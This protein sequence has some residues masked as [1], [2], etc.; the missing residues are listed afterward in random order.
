MATSIWN[1]HY[2]S[3]I[4]QSQID[5]MLQKMYSEEALFNQSKSG[6]NFYFIQDSNNINVGFLSYTIQKPDAC[7]INKFYISSTQQGKGLGKKVFSQLKNSLTGIKRFQLT[8]NRQNYKAINFYFSLGFKIEKCED[9]DIGNG[10]F[11]NDFVMICS[12]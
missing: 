2:R 3:I 10:Y 4:G 11:M 7:F 6:Q 12:A 5:Y 1:D 8:V 9:F